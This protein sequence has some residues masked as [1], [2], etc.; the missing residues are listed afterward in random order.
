MRV[1]RQERI[2][3][4]RS[5]GCRSSD[6]LNSEE[7]FILLTLHRK[8]NDNRELTSFHLGTV[9]IRTVGNKSTGVKMLRGRAVSG[10]RACRVR[11]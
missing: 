8:S 9:C 6:S 11:Y 10:N 2:D 5:R 1:E 3:R 4:A 7:A